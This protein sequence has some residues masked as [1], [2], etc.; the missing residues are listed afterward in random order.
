[1][2]KP[3]CYNAG[4]FAYFNVFRLI[5]NREYDRIKLPL[6]VE[7]SHATVG[8]VEATARDISEGGIFVE[9]PDSGLTVGAQVKV[10]LRARHITD[11]QY[12]PTV[13]VKVARL[14][15]DGLALEF[16][17]KTAEH[18]WT[19][20]ERLRDE[21]SLKQDF[22][23]VYQ[24]LLVS[25][26]ERG[27]LF[28]Q[29]HGKWTFPGVYLEA[30]DNPIEKLEAL[31]KDD[32]GIEAESIKPLLTKGITHD[33]LPEASTFCVAYETQ[34]E[35]RLPQPSYK[36]WRWINKPGELADITVAF[37]FIRELAEAYL[38]RSDND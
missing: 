32:L 35:E 13:D 37:P 26:A 15:D 34:T 11:F 6:L 4:V 8:T 25:H 22:F 1:M 5:E 19:S 23:Q 2:A 24:I 17:N 9:L 7:V 33:A 30:S 14:A 38:A 10:R 36:D 27:M 29:Q 21:L 12:A 18:L 28:V 16:K 20:V 3:S 31:C